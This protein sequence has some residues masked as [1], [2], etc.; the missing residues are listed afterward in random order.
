MRQRVTFLHR[1]GDAVDPS[2]LRITENSLTGPQEIRAAREVRTTLALDE[3]P[4][5]LASVLKTSH[6]LHVR[7]VASDAFDTVTPLHSRLS[8]G[9]HLFFTPRQGGDASESETLCR[10]LRK[11]FGGLENCQSSK[12]S[13]IALSPD[14]FSHSAAFQFYQPLDDLAHFARHVRDELCPEGDPLC[15]AQVERLTEAVSLDLSYD[16]ISHTLKITA[17]SPYQAQP[18]LV[19]GHSHHRTDHP[20]T[21]P[22]EYQHERVDPYARLSDMLVNLGYDGLF[23]PRT[24]FWHVDPRPSAGTRLFTR[25]DV[26]VL[27]LNKARWVGPGTA[28]VVLLGFAWVVWKLVGV[29]VGG[30]GASAVPESKV[31]ETKK[32]K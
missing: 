23:G 5:E 16:T 19:T 28:A 6:E 4:A 1:P 20:A 31:A 11:A 14:R 3:L 10:L 26:P 2:T 15:R 18:L 13:F 22:P 12:D 21:H 30:R 29:A 32:T 8:P 7:W 25:V 17:L 27:D 24:V 9:F